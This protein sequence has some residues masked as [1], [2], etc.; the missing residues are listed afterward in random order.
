MYLLDTMVL[1]EMERRRP[2][3]AVA[4][5]MAAQRASDLYISV[6]TI[7]EIER[8]IER[9]RSRDPAH[10][11]AIVQWLDVVLQVYG[12]RIIPVTVPVARRWGQLSAR[13]GNAGA[14]IVI[15]ATAL[16]HGLSIAT[17]NVAHFAPTGVPIVNPFEDAPALNRPGTRS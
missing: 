2:S 1:S 3:K 5:W 9:Q 4:A 14:D 15:A 6:L 11:A 7:G 13:V 8:G 12:D 16:E 10:A 17:R